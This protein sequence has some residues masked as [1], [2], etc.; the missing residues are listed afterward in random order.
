MT[1][2]KAR[3]RLQEI[4]KDLDVQWHSS[5]AAGHEEKYRELLDDVIVQIDELEFQL[6]KSWLQ[7]LVGATKK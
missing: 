6:N 3:K 2:S 5:I 7:D 1:K 4:S